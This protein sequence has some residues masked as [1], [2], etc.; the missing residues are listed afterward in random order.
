M[1][2]Q[3]TDLIVA[4]VAISGALV[5][6]GIGVGPW[7]PPYKLRSIAPVVERYGLSAGRCIWIV[8]ALVSLVAGMAIASGVRPGYARPGPD[9]LESAQ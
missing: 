9:Q 5:S 7:E 2:N 8:I 6:F 3:Y 4:A 1:T